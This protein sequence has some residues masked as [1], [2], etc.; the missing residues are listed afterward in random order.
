V[1]VYLYRPVWGGV[2]C[3]PEPEGGEVSRIDLYS[4]PDRSGTVVATAGP[5]VRV[6]ENEYRFT[7]PD[8]L[9]DGRYWC[10]VAFTPAAETSPATD[11]T[12]RLDLPLGTGLIAS[13][14][15]LADE[16]GVPLPLDA[17]QRETFRDSLA[18]AQADVAGYL[19]RPLV[20]K[21]MVL[22]NV[23]LRPF[24]PLSDARAW[25]LPDVDDSVSVAGWEQNDDETYT[26][27]ILVGLNAAAEEPIV[28]YV[29]AHAA[30]RHRNSP[31]GEAAAGGR[32]VSSVSADGQSISYEASPVAGQAGAL[33]TLDSLGDYRKR[34]WRTIATAPAS[35]WPYGGRR[36]SRW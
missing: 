11:R 31:A 30:E 25:P 24:Y 28:R 3:D 4:A 34:L 1:A 29:V 12:V 21:P 5:A 33:P 32:R 19:K 8:N 22:R 18:K 35:P 10:T 17:V 27:R 36:Y 9:P 2:L 26:V 14:E 15:Q 23:G 20:P 13:P 7:I 6:G 16:L